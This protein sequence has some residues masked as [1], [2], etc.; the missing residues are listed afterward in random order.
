MIMC[1]NPQCFG[2]FVRR[3]KPRT[4]TKKALFYDEVCPECKGEPTHPLP[5][6]EQLDLLVESD[7]DDYEIPF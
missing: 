2:G 6:N 7:D 3:L 5:I 4:E 1:E